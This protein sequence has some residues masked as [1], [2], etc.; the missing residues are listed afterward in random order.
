[1]SHS[2]TPWTYACNRSPGFTGETPAGVPVM[3]MSPGCSVYIAEADQRGIR[4][5][6]QAPVAD[7]LLDVGAPV[8]DSRVLGRLGD[9]VVVVDRRADDFRGVRHGRE[10]LHP[11][12]GLLLR[13]GREL[14]RRGEHALEVHDQGIAL[15]DRPAL[16]R[17]GGERL[18][19]VEDFVAF[20]DSEAVVVVAADFHLFTASGC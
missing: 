6:E 16:L 14:L 19:D 2:P 13:L 12:K 1:M 4:L 17:N 15:R 18:A 10:H 7:A 3:M 9:V 11:G 8:R 5:E 20:H